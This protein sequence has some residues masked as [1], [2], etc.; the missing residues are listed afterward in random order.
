MCRCCQSCLEDIYWNCI[1]EKFCF[2][3][4]IANYNPD[5]DDFISNDNIKI[6]PGIG[7]GQIIDNVN[8]PIMTQPLNRTN[9]SLMSGK[10]HEE[11]YR[12][13]IQTSVPIL[14]PEILAVFANS[15]IFQDNQSKGLSRVNTKTYLPGIHSGSIKDKLENDQE[16]LLFHLEGSQLSNKDELSSHSEKKIKFTLSDNTPLEINKSPSTQKF[17][18]I[19]ENETDGD[20]INN[21]PLSSNKLYNSTSTNSINNNDKNEVILR[22]R[23]RTNDDPISML[24]KNAM[25]NN[26]NLRNQSY[27]SVRPVASENDIFSISGLGGSYGQLSS[28]PEVPSISYSALPKNYE[29]TPTIEKY[30]ES[31]SLFSIQTANQKHADNKIID[32]SMPRCYRKTLAA[33]KSIDCINNQIQIQNII[34]SGTKS[35]YTSR[36][37]INQHIKKPEKSKRLKNLRDSLPPLLIHTVRKKDEP[38]QIN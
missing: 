18:I 14:A 36:D 28:T 34:I 16:K 4:S 15:Q 12:R 10:I 32:Y 29:D 5:D 17:P 9:T 2:D 35:N 25:E 24:R 38:K 30:K 33:T 26:N 23:L 37:N 31:I 20:K 7:N 13:E 1:E 3:E 19:E 8:S 27:Y 6:V 11:D 22:P 21:F